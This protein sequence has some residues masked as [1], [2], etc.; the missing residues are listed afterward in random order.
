VSRVEFEGEGGGVGA[1]RRGGGGGGKQL[2]ISYRKRVLNYD[3]D[4]LEF[5]VC[6]EFHSEAVSASECSSS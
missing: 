1:G 4:P 2:S 6:V 5:L 3:T